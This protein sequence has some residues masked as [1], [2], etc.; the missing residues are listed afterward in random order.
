MGCIM[1]KVKTKSKEVSQSLLCLAIEQDDTKGACVLIESGYDIEQKNSEGKSP[2]W[3]ALLKRNG[4]VFKLL[5]E[6]GAK[7][8]ENH[9]EQSLLEYALLC[10]Q[11]EIAAILIARGIKITNPHFIQKQGRTAV[12]FALLANEIEIVRFL[13]NEGVIVKNCLGINEENLLHVAAYHNRA[14]AISLLIDNGTLINQRNQKGE[15]PLHVALKNGANETAQILIAKG[16]NVLTSTD[17]GRS[18]LGLSIKYCDVKTTASILK[19]KVSTETPTGFDV[20][21][22]Q[23]AIME[24][25]FEEAHLLLEAGASVNPPLNGDHQSPLVLAIQK[26][27]TPL[28]EALLKKKANLSQ[29]SNRGEGI[30]VTAIKSK[31]PEIARLLIEAGVKLNTPENA[32]AILE[33]AK[34]DALSLVQLLA[35]KGA[36]IHDVDPELGSVIHILAT[37]NTPESKELINLLIAKGVKDAHLD[38]RNGE[39]LTPLHIAVQ[40]RE[41]ELAALF[42]KNGASSK[43]TDLRGHS[44]LGTAVFNEDLPT[45]SALVQ[46]EISPF[47]LLNNNNHLLRQATGNKDILYCLFSSLYAHNLKFSFLN[48]FKD[49]LLA[50]FYRDFCLETTRTIQR[51]KSMQSTKVNFQEADYTKKLPRDIVNLILPD[52]GI[53]REIIPQHFSARYKKNIEAVLN[54]PRYNIIL[55]MIESGIHLNEII[56]EEENSLLHVAIMNGMED[57]ALTL[58]EAGEDIHKK[59]K[60]EFTPLHLAIMNGQL[61]VAQR[62]MLKGADVNAIHQERGSPLE[63]AL[64]SNQLKIFNLLLENE[65]NIN[66]QDSDGNTVLHKAALRRYGTPATSLLI[67]K[68]ANLTLRN[69]DGKTPLWYHATSRT[70]KDLILNNDNITFEHLRAKAVGGMHEDGKSV[71]Y[72][73]MTEIPDRIDWFWDKFSQDITVEDLREGFPSILWRFC[74][75]AIGRTFTFDK[76]WQ[77]FKNEI[78]VEDL[79]MTHE[80]RSIMSLMHFIPDFDFY[81]VWDQFKYQMTM[82]DL[83]HFHLTFSL[84]HENP[85]II[86]LLTEF[87]KQLPGKISLSSE[88]DQ[89]RIWVVSTFNQI[90]ID[91]SFRNDFVEALEAAQKEADFSKV[92]LEALFSAAEKAQDSSYYYNAYY[93]LGTWLKP[94]NTEKAYEAF[95]RVPKESWHYEAINK[96]LAEQYLAQAKAAEEDKKEDYLRKALSS[97]IHASSEN[98]TVLIKKIA[99]IATRCENETLE[100]KDL[101]ITL[102]RLCQQEMSVDAWFIYF[103]KIKEDRKEVQS[104]NQVQTALLAQLLAMRSELTSLRQVVG[105]LNEKVEAKEQIQAAPVI[106]FL[107]KE[108]TTQKD[109]VTSQATDTAHAPERG[110]ALSR[111]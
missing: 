67:Q 102:S 62:L 109:P 49:E 55:T 43:I 33:A 70:F 20:T 23:L 79:R 78:T 103:H 106:R 42:L 21:A 91:V 19:R 14:E 75:K 53:L 41:T 57:I 25:K 54:H 59:N 86:S 97:A 6:K 39:G 3:L 94:L 24:D 110:P 95:T 2:I 18:P 74:N 31:K 26:G 48:T 85:K 83:C 99:L 30:I 32:S 38:I 46:Y 90:A 81:A 63:M 107:S 28:V 82:A 40:N 16:A 12:I 80:H 101:P 104:R 27:N 98:R 93:E 1:L 111:W 65:A 60:N 51:I 29:N 56:N 64:S 7:L 22:L 50:P 87:F 71:F 58:I 76:L 69:Q 88:T 89:Y 44:C 52:N 37:K 68:G 10:S 4:E 92:N 13:I 84:S 45:L 105:S 8:D 66:L 61:R 100:E 36:D 77:Q 96:E 34:N 73:F 108:E 47:V 11:F 15:T 9:N 35:E 72:H 17:E 5:V